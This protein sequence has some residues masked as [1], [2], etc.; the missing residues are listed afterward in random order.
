MERRRKQHQIQPNPLE[1]YQTDAAG[2]IKRYLHWSP[3]SGTAEQPGQAQI[4]EAYNLAI[5]QQLEK[6][7]YEMGEVGLDEMEAW[8]P[9]QT[10]QNWIRVESGNLVGK[11]KLAAGLFSHFFDVFPDSIIY[12]FAPSYEQINDLLWKEIRKDRRN[13]QRPG[14]VLETP[15]LNERPNHF[16]TGKATSNSNDTGIERIHGQHE[17]YLMFVLDEAEGVGDFVY[18]AIEGMDTGIVVIV[19][20]LANPRTRS[21]TFH[22]LAGRDYVK[23]FRISTLTHPNVVQG[24][25]TIPGAATRD[26]VVRRLERYAEVVSEHSEDEGTFEIAWLPGQIFRPSPTFF[27]RVLG[28]APTNVAD[29]TFCPIGRYEAAQKRQPFTGDDPQKA[30]LGIDA[31]RYGGDNGTL[32]IRHAG[33]IWRAWLF[34]KND[35]YEYYRR[36]K[37]AIRL[38]VAQGVKDIEVRVDGGGGY[39][40]TA[41]DN[42]NHD[43]EL[44]RGV[45]LTRILKETGQVLEEGHPFLGLERFVVREVHNNAVPYEASSFA[46]LVTEMYYHC[47]EA[48]K[49]LRLE[50]PPDNLEMELCER[51]FSYGTLNGVE[52]KKL[53]SKE[54]FKAKKKRSPDDGDGCV[55]AAAPDFIFKRRRE[56]HMTSDVA[57]AED[58]GLM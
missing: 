16:A 20:L 5:R 13:N 33:V 29:D 51:T 17:P 14:R 18:E 50:S 53:I 37:N 46:D 21:S 41:I 47:A 28:I 35:G 27:W 36:A 38:L 39:A 32:Y 48:L 3:W 7:A 31:A 49:V 34:H 57:T 26:W 54:Q 56:G 22:K 9:G 8:Q 12:T 58:L 2:Y 55:L 11:T 24:K 19:L 42:L 4:V 44:Q 25:Q 1:R 45:E 52:V 15:R 23:S 43:I 30:R 40:S 6:H 10:I